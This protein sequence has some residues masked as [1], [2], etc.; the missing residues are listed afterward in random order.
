MEN[1]ELDKWFEND[2]KNQELLKLYE[3]KWNV[4]EKVS[5][6][7]KDEENWLVLL[8][9]S[10]PYN[11]YKTKNKILIIGQENNG[12]S[13]FETAKESMRYTLGFQNIT[14]WEQ[15]PIF[16][17]PYNFCKSINECDDNETKKSYLAWTNLKKFSFDDTPKK[18]LSDNIQKII[19]EEFN[20][21]EDE[22]KIINPDIILFLTGPDYDIEIKTQ[23]KDI[24]FLPIEGYSIREFAR[25]KH[26]SLPHNSFRVYHP[27]YLRRSGREEEYLIKLKEECNL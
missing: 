16:T 4:I 14:R 1:N 9:A 17:F 23:L 21:L 20:V 7:S 25:L 10:I 3:S 24:E 13:Y 19:D 2:A 26:N 18:S 22:I 12:W 11:Y 8:L 6:I 27:S 15:Y 5:E